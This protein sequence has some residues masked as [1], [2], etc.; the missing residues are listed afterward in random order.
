MFSKL[1][2]EWDL[3]QVLIDKLEAFTCLLYVPK[4]TSNNINDLRYHLFCA[5][6]GEIE[7]HQPPPCKDCLDNHA[8]RAN[9][10]AALWRRCLE[11]DPKVPS[12]VNRGWKME[13]EGAEEQLVLHWMD[14]KP[15]P[16][17]ILDLLACNCTRKCELPKC[18]CMANG[19]KCTDMCK[20]S[21]CE[22]QA[23]CT[24]ED[25]DE[26]NYDEELE[27]DYEY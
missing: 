4:T 9:F 1:G 25:L 24:N 2:R 13:R 6:K 5:K 14:G 15:A 3:S 26:Q 22:N 23:L 27:D 12:P 20:L 8:K 17:A 18:V 19:L 16:Q 11:K 21:D 7:S 10:Q